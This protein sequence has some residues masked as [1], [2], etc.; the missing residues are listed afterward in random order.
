MPPNEGNLVGSAGIKVTADT[1]EV[2]PK[3]DAVKAK[4]QEIGPVAGTAKSEADALFKSMVD[5]GNK[6]ADAAEN[7]AK[8][9]AGVGVAVAASTV[10][11]VGAT[12]AII[13]LKAAWD[14]YAEKAKEDA[15]ALHKRQL[16][17]NKSFDE[18]IRATTDGY[19]KLNKAPS[20]ITDD[21]V[22]GIGAAKAE[23]EE[24][25]KAGEDPAILSELFRR[26][27][28]MEA[29]LTVER[30]K[31]QQKRLEEAAELERQS[32]EKTA[33]AEQEIEEKKRKEDEASRKAINSGDEARIKQLQR[34]LEITVKIG[35]TRI[36]DILAAEAALERMYARQAAGFNG[37][38]SNN[39]LQGSIDALEIAVRGA[40]ARMGGT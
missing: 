40:A 10:A 4:L 34:E 19:K 2:G 31:E 25:V 3:I 27:K 22:R 36:K 5:E 13:A 28:K 33:K 14:L 21:L 11:S 39:S 29:D 32:L 38:G 9:T 23:F 35:Q 12:V 24:L 37:E 30:K 26:I 1:S 20:S 16:E 6:A 15:E 8:K 7:A 17:L 18:F